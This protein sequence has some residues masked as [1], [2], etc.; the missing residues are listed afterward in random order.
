MPWMSSGWLAAEAPSEGE[1]SRT[2]VI[3]GFPAPGLQY[4]QMYDIRIWVRN[5]S[6]LSRAADLV[7]VQV[8]PMGEEGEEQYQGEPYGAEG[9]RGDVLDLRKGE[10]LPGV[11]RTP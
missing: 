3:S 10:Q 2:I 11:R 1:M 9:Q 7:T 6:G 4:N 8:V 5:R